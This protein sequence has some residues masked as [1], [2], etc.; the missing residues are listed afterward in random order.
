MSCNFETH[1]Y[2][3]LGRV[4]ARLEDVL[5]RLDELEKK[6]ESHQNKLAWYSGLHKAAVGTASIVGAA[7]AYLLQLFL[8]RH[9]G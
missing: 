3:S 6:V 5:R 7:A 4:E 8:G 1:V 2:A 9:H